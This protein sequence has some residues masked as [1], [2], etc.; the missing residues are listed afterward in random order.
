MIGNIFGR[1]TVIEE[2]AERTK[3]RYIQYR[4]ACS[5][6]NQ[7]IVTGK[8]L[9][10]GTSSCGCIQ[11]EFVA[12]LNR[13]NDTLIVTNHPLYSRWCGMKQR[14]LSETHHK[15]QNYGG[16]GITVCDEWIHSFLQFANDMGE[17]PEGYS[18]DRINNDLGYSK[19]N[20]K[21][22]SPIEQANNRR[23]RNSGKMC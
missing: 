4:C 1:L 14:C 8:Q 16:R 18:L 15:Y 11:K 21:W 5:C 10:R 6:G 2:L 20:C 17:C 9:R 22:S 19:E 13:V 12:N 3:D 7:K 23:K